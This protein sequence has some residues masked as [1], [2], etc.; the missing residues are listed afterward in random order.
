MT[1]QTPVADTA[2]DTLKTERERVESLVA[3]GRKHDIGIEKIH[4]F[5]QRGITLAE[6]RAVLEAAEADANRTL[7]SPDAEFESGKGGKLEALAAQKKRDEAMKSM[8]VTD[9]K[10]KASAGRLPEGK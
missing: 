6:A 9:G 4:A 1:T 8:T 10:S 7:E 5:I 2:A 3:L